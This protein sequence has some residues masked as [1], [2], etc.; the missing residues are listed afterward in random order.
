MNSG[1]IR[2]DGDRGVQFLDNSSPRDLGRIARLAH[3]T[4]AQARCRPDGFDTPI[5]LKVTRPSSK[6]ASLATLQAPRP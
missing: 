4:T 1:W 2:C 3:A 5:T 6:T